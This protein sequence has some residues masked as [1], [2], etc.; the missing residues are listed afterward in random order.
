M[1]MFAW[2]QFPLTL[3]SYPDKCTNTSAL[4]TS[5][6]TDSWY[7]ASPLHDA[8]FMCGSEPVGVLSLTF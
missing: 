3:A 4:Q 8:A 7:T 2:R 6:M 1:V 5:R